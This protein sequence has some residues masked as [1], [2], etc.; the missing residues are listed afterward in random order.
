KG[1]GDREPKVV[2]PM[3]GGKPVGVR[4]AEEGRSE[5]PGPAAHDTARTVSALDP[6]R[7]VRRRAYVALVVA[8]LRPL[9]DIAHHVVET[10]PVRGKRA[11]RRGLP[12]V[13]L[14]ATGGAVGIVRA[15]GIAPGIAV[16]VPARVAYSYS[17]PESS[18]YDLP[19]FFDSQA[20]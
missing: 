15:D 2:E 12:G 19:V 8:I 7:A 1:E 6:S 9:T 20:T 17:A 13:P 10:E 14:A 5:E 18:R 11:D 16:C 4:R 3:V